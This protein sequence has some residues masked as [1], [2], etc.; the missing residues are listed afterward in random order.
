MWL[1][2][3]CLLLSSCL[4]QMEAWVLCPLQ[5]FKLFLHNNVGLAG[6]PLPSL[7]S[8]YGLIKFYTES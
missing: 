3:P 1:D 6:H 8:S 2:T 7:A 4:C 5:E